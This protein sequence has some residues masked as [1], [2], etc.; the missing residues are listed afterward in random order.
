MTYYSN[1]VCTYDDFFLKFIDANGPTTLTKN[2]QCAT[3]LS[4]WL[5]HPFL[6]SDLE[7]FVSVCG[8]LPPLTE[9]LRIWLVSCPLGRKLQESSSHNGH[10]TSQ[11][12]LEMGLFARYVNYSGENGSIQV[13]TIR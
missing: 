12:K 7:L 1:V 13:L 2:L 9:P 3:E 6:W 5:F 11:L 8:R 10:V 4:S